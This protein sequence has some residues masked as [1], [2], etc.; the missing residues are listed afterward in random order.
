MAAVLQRQSYSSASAHEIRTHATKDS[1]P[2][3][4]ALRKYSMRI[5][6]KESNQQKE[7]RFE[8]IISKQSLSSSLI[9]LQ[10]VF[11][12]MPCQHC[13]L[14]ARGHVGDVLERDCLIELL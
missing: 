7:D 9:L 11:Q 1:I 12:R 3:F 10:H 4:Y 6:V 14:D 13:T 8:R 2:C 5:I